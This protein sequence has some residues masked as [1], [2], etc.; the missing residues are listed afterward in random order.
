MHQIPTLFSATAYKKHM[1]PPT[2]TDPKCSMFIAFWC[3]QIPYSCEVLLGKFKERMVETVIDAT[4]V[5]SQESQKGMVIGKGG[6]KIKEVGIKAR[7]V[8]ARGRKRV[9]KG[10]WRM[11][12]GLVA[13]RASAVLLK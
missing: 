12:N 10:E 11:E 5:V 8:S 4:I 2:L 3:K 6:A 7:V 1:K 13:S 9:K